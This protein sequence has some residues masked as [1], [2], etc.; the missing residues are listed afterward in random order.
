MPDD[1]EVCGDL[2]RL[3]DGHQPQP[4]DLDAVLARGRRGLRRRRYLS[5]G[6]S[7]AGIAAI[8]LTAAAVPGLTAAKQNAQPAGVQSENSQFGPVP[9]VPRG[10]AGADQR[11]SKA[12]A[13]RRCALQHPEVKVP[14]EGSGFR[15]GWVAMYEFKAGA[16]Y[17][18]CTVP[19]GDRPAPAL[20][21]AAAKDPVPTSMADKLRNCSVAAWV[22][23]THWRVVASDET[24]GTAASLV[25]ISPSGN[26]ALGCE[27]SRL[28]AGM[29]GS[30]TSTRFLTLDKLGQADPVFDPASGPD[31][32]D[33]YIGGGGGGP[34][35][36]KTCKGWNESG[37]GRV[38]SKAVKVSFRIGNGPVY[39]VPVGT[40]GW[41]AYTWTDKASHP[42]GK[43]PNVTAY[44]SHG[45]VVKKF[46]S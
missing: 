17:A 28:P 44:D 16:K 32:R 23:A 43:Y 14:L 11:L 45:K 33:L 20:I 13:T 21:K 42:L 27:L 9:G 40:D 7:V 34:C 5:A 29:P 10:E 2:R 30:A 26:K 39:D 35:T 15:S 36:A 3:A 37:W 8:A 24:K 6:G 12:E 41:F 19:G 25:A 46:A 1:P 18:E 22:D 31:H 38:S 4:V